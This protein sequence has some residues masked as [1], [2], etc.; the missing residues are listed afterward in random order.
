MSI[1]I[2]GSV[3]M[4]IPVVAGATNF[5]MTFKGSWHKISGS[6]TL[7]FYL[8]GI[9]FY[10]TGSLQGTAEAF[11][12]TNLVWHFTDFTVA[13]AHLGFY[14]IITFALWGGFYVVIP[15][16]TGKE[17]PQHLVGVHFWLALIGLILYSV[18][19]SIGSTLRGLMWMEG[20]PFIDS[21]VLMFD[22]WLWRAIGGSLMF[23]SHLVFAYNFYQMTTK[24]VAEVDV[25]EE[26]FKILEQQ[27][28]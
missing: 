3:G 12:F 1:A 23:I 21:V 22:F 16:L 26:A 13:H 9:I 10:F 6:Y 11:R 7:P 20:K 15:R 28:K 19:L 5:L 14:G 24:E 4:I 2:V 8:I 17:P 25:K 27:I 18:P